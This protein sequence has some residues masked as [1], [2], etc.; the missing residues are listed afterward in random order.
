MTI[1][2]EF[3]LLKKHRDAWTE[4]EK[5]IWDC[6]SRWLADVISYKNFLNISSVWVP[7]AIYTDDLLGGK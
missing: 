1:M 6:Y 5:T 4:E 3:N 7:L 2:C